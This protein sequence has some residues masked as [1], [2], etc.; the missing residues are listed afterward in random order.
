MAI[1]KPL[2]EK[3]LI[4]DD[5]NKI[6]KALIT[7]VNNPKVKILIG[8]VI[9]IKTGLTKTLIIPKN[10]ASHKAVQ[11]PATTTPGIKYELIIIAKTIT[12]HLIIK[13]IIFYLIY[14]SGPSQ[15]RTGVSA[16]CPVTYIC[17]LTGNRTRTSTMRM[18]RNTVLL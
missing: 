8:K 18:S 5:A 13:D 12:S 11:K 15:N 4:T 1:Q 16:T 3:P 14:N 2:T 17:G 9:K 7:K 6:S 10:K